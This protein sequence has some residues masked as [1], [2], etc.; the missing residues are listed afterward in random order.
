MWL[1]PTINV[2][3]EVSHLTLP[4]YFVPSASGGNKSYSYWA[5]Y[6]FWKKIKSLKGP[7]GKEALVY[8]W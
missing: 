1:K 8:V 7:P 5:A 6:N 3:S 4:F 2:P